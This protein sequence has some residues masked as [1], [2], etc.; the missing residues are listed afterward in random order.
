MVADT[1][2]SRHSGWRSNFAAAADKRRGR[3]G[4]GVGTLTLQP[5]KAHVRA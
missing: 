5:A 3:T 4:F 2:S 1:V